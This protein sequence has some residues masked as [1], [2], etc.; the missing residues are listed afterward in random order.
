MKRVLAAVV[1][2]ALC[3]CSDFVNNSKACAVMCQ[4]HGVVLFD[5]RS[6]EICVCREP[7]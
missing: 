4:P 1:V 6:Q 2:L 3:S 7:K 5:N